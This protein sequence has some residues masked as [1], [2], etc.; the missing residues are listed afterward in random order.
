MAKEKKT[1][2]ERK[3]EEKMDL[4]YSKPVV[5]NSEIHR[6]I[7]IAPVKNYKF[8]KHMNSCIVTGF[9][10]FEAAKY[11]PIVFAKSQNDEVMPVVIL[12]VTDNVFVDED[13]KWKE[14]YYIPAFIRRYPYILTKV[15]DEEGEKLLVTI[16]SAYEG[17]DAEEGD[18]L[19]DD[20]GKNTPALDRAIEFLKAY[21]AQFE[22]TRQFVK[23]LEELDL[24]T[25]VNANIRLADGKTYLM[26]DLMVVDEGK[27]LKLSDEDLLSLVRMNGNQRGYIAWIYAHIFSINNFA[28][29]LK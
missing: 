17:F 6:N 29:I 4:L 18:R 16:D 28:K 15:E 1:K 24:F 23:R 20:E 21:N 10:F 9:E 3:E 12:G 22:V 11:Y 26:R 19:F 27:M 25:T 5:L 2:K 8:A 14:G 13:G 7:K